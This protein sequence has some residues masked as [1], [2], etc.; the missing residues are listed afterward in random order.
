MKLKLD[1][2]LLVALAVVSC[3]TLIAYVVRLLTE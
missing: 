2:F 1:L 3:L